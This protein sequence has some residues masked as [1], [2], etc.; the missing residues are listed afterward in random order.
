LKFAFIVHKFLLEHIATIQSYPKGGRTMKRS[1]NIPV[2]LVALALFFSGCAVR[3]S[4]NG[5]IQDESPGFTVNK[6]HA[7]NYYQMYGP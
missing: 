2:V 6:P 3:V 1:I 4:S 7:L 5:Y